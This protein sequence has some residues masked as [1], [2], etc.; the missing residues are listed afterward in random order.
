MFSIEESEPS[1]IYLII[2]CGPALNG[3]ACILAKTSSYKTLQKLMHW[4]AETQGL[5]VLSLPTLIYEEIMVETYNIQCTTF[6]RVVID[7]YVYGHWEKDSL[8]SIVNRDFSKITMK[9][10]EY[11]IRKLNLHKLIFSIQKEK[12]EQYS[13]PQ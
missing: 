11:L 7:P 2:Y 1:K 5:P 9:R 10:F 4:I 13:S 12:V 6:D 8:W 3:E